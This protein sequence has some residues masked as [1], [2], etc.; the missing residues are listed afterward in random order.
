MI[1]KYASPRSSVLITYSKNLLVLRTVVAKRRDAWHKAKETKPATIPLQSQLVIKQTNISR[2]LLIKAISRLTYCANCNKCPGRASEA[3]VVYC[4]CRDDTPAEL[5][6]LKESSGA[7]TPRRIIINDTFNAAPVPL[8]SPGN[9]N[10][11][12][13]EV[14]MCNTVTRPPCNATKRGPLVGQDMHLVT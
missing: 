2:Q 5:V 12:S 3:A 9:G 1:S 13:A 11:P 8:Q 7:T 14:R 10:F 4:D 6:N